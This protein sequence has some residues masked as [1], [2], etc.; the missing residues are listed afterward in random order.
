MMAFGTNQTDQQK[1]DIKLDN[2]SKKSAKPPKR[3][4]NNSKK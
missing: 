1:S 4:K 3:I 2:N